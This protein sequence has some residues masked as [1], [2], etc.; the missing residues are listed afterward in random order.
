V[1]PIRL[2]KKDYH[3]NELN[4]ATVRTMGFGP[5]TNAG[6][7]KIQTLSKFKLLFEI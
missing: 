7:T 3:G 1:Y 6:N 2:V 4:L 5:A